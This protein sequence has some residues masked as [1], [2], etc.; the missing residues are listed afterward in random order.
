[1]QKTINSVLRSPAARALILVALIIPVSTYLGTSSVR[2]GFLYHTATFGPSVV[3]AIAT[4]LWTWS[5]K[6]FWITLGASGA[7]TMLVQMSLYLVR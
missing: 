1:M 7:L 2:R 3:A 6:W 5:W 4:G